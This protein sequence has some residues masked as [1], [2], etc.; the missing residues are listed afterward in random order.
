MKGR[1]LHAT[2]VG[3]TI[4]ICSNTNATS[5]CNKYGEGVG[6]DDGLFVLENT[7]MVRRFRRAT[8]TQL[9]S[10]ACNLESGK[11]QPLGHI[12]QHYIRPTV[13]TMHSG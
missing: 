6:R 7:F 8:C 10:D 1:T 3:A 2:R 11:K 9:I 13:N 5:R 12:K 4:L